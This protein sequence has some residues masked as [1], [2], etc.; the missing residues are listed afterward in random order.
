VIGIPPHG[1]KWQNFRKIAEL[2]GHLICLGRSIEK[3]DTFETMTILIQTDILRRIEDEIIFHIED[4]GFRIVVKE[5]SLVSPV[6]QKA[7]NLYFHVQHDEDAASNEG[8]PGFEDVESGS[9]ADSGMMQT[10]HMSEDTPNHDLEQENP[11]HVL[12]RTQAELITNSNSN[13]EVEQPEEAA[14]GAS[15]N[16]DS[17]TKTAVFSQNEGSDG[18]RNRMLA[19]R[20]IMVNEIAGQST[21][22][23]LIEPPGFERRVVLAQDPSKFPVVNADNCIEN[24]NSNPEP[25]GVQE[26][27]DENRVTRTQNANAGDGKIPAENKLIKTQGAQQTSSSSTEGSVQKIAKE[28]E[29]IGNIL[30][31]KVVQNGKINA[32]KDMRLK[33]TKKPLH[34]DRPSKR[35]TGTQQ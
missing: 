30:G 5:L 13:K 7:H 4:L 32:N 17:R 12:K 22:E 26:T 29:R 14:E 24:F 1:W 9:E 33:T 3:T 35:G 16:T 15:M 23:S 31:L 21:E 25:I 18:I 28:I 10:V 19:S 11:D 6:L 27:Y 8:V 34:R 2:W 20:S